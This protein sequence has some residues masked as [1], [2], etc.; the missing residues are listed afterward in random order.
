MVLSKIIFP[1]TT[2]EE[3]DNYLNEVEKYFRDTYKEQYINLKEHRSDAHKKQNTYG[4]IGFTSIILFTLG[5]FG[6][7][8]VLFTMYNKYIVWVASIFLM[9]TMV[10]AI[11]YEIRSRIWH[12]KYQEYD[13]QIDE[14]F[15][16]IQSQLDKL[17]IFLD[18]WSY[19]CGIFTDNVNF[20]IDKCN[21]HWYKCFE[22]FDTI[23]DE[24]DVRVSIHN[25]DVT[26]D[27]Y[28]ND[29]WFSSKTF[30]APPDRE[31]FDI[32]TKNIIGDQYDFSFF[33]EGY[34]N[35]MKKFEKLKKGNEI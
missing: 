3:V 6:A 25:K 1:K 9:L 28:I 5:L 21:S 4:N 18:T 8:A 16:T 11:I 33:D 32:M 19:L 34:E 29:T 27:T 20:L 2:K 10:T 17:G 31:T 12:K 13:K 7:T 14:L 30:G 22:F 26:F 24:P 35:R 15:D 23:K